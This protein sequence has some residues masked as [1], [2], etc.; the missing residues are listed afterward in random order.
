MRVRAVL[1]LLVKAMFVVSCSN[2]S[3][4]LP[5]TAVG[6][7][8][9]EWTD[10]IASCLEAGGAKVDRSNPLTVGAQAGTGMSEDTMASLYNRC[11]SEAGPVPPPRSDAAFAGRTY[12]GYLA[13]ADCLRGLGYRI[14]PAPSRQAFI[15]SFGTDGGGWN[16]YQSIFAQVSSQDEQATAQQRCPV[17]DGIGG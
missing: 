6:L 5:T 2:A 8:A 12:D 3:V 14:D 13:A 9:A 1:P 11:R 15:D 10:K 7:S 16:P 4:S 17:W